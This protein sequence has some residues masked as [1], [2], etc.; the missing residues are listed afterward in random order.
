PNEGIRRFK[1]LTSD[2]YTNLPF[3]NANPYYFG[4]TAYGY[5][6]HSEPSYLESTPVILEVFPGKKRID[7]STPYSSGDNIVAQRV[8]GAGDQLVRFKAIDPDAFTGDTYRVEFHDDGSGNVYY[9]LLDKTTGDTLVAQE[10]DFV[11]LEK[12]EF[13]AWT[14]FDAD[15]SSRK[16]YDGFQLLVQDLAADTLKILPTKYHVKSV[17]EVKGP[18]GTDL[19]TPVN[20]YYSPNST[21]KWMI[22]AKGANNRL[23]W[24]GSGQDALGFTNYEI[25]FTGESPYYLNGYGF[26]FPST[27]PLLNDDKAANTLPFEIWDVGR[28]L[29]STADDVRLAIKIKDHDNLDSTA[30]VSDSVWTQLPNG[31]WEEVYAFEPRT[32]S[33]DTTIDAWPDKSGPTTFGSHRFG[34]LVFSGDLPEPG[35]VIRIESWKIAAE[36]D[37]FEAKLEAPKLSDLT[38]AKK[39]LDDGISVFPNPYFGSNNLELDK[40]RRFVRFTGLP[41]KATIRIYSLSGIFI[42]KY[43][44]NDTSPFWDWNLLNKDGLPVAS[45]MYIAYLDLPGIGTKVMKLA[46]IQ[47]QQYIDRL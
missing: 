41:V 16:L 34:A 8:E 19:S 26:G 18:G 24:Q 23:N 7:Y 15:T 13:G 40:Y 11:G 27:I 3:L 45:G 32:W 46:I 36:G 22:K 10:Y 42:T 47:E 43:D 17:T 1:F 4:I 14:I 33:A 21:G 30:A 35:T 6:P 28:D 20:V 9:N 37:A 31:D 2:A 12:D 39:N 5:S 38:A 29:N 44:K 25:R